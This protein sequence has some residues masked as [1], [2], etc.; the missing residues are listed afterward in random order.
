MAVDRKVPQKPGLVRH[1]V[2]FDN[3]VPTIPKDPKAAWAILSHKAEDDT[4]VIAKVSLPFGQLFGY[5]STDQ[6]E[7]KNAEVLAPTDLLPSLATAEA[8]LIFQLKALCSNPVDG[9]TNILLQYMAPFV[10]CHGKSFMALVEVQ[11]IYCTAKQP[12]KEIWHI[13]EKYSDPT[14]SGNSSPQEVSDD[15]EAFI[16]LCNASSS[17]APIPIQAPPLPLSQ[18]QQPAS[19]LMTTDPSSLKYE[20]AEEFQG[21]VKAVKSNSSFGDPFENYLIETNP[22][23]FLSN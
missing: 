13:L 19:S 9:C 20:L 15:I 17:S 6:L 10:D 11:K 2:F 8:N 16:A 21:G 23:F 12:Q 3:R 14:T 5:D 4:K 22:E 18:Q 1:Q 7:R